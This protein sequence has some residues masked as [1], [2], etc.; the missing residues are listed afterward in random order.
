MTDAKRLFNPAQPEDPSVT[1]QVFD[2]CSAAVEKARA[3]GSRASKCCAIATPI[4]R[5]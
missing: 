1:Q 2:I 3:A 4:A 5:R